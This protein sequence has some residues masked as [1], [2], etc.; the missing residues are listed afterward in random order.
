MAYLSDELLDTEGGFTGW[1]D[2][3][4]TCLLYTS[5]RQV[6]NTVRPAVFLMEPVN[7]LLHGISGPD[8][9]CLNLVA[10]RHHQKSS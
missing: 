9:L 6:G 7:Y 3:T 2:G 4:G 5:G 10:Y 8:D 1:D